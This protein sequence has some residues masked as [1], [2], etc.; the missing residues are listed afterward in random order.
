MKSLLR[1]IASLATIAVVG[2]AAASIEFYDI[3]DD[4]NQPILNAPKLIGGTGSTAITISIPTTLTSLSG[5]TAQLQLFLSD[6]E[7]QPDGEGAVIASLMDKKINIAQNLTP[8]WY[9]WT[10]DAMALMQQSTSPSQLWS[11]SRDLTSQ[12]SSKDFFYYNARLVFT[13]VPEAS[14][15]LLLGVGAMVAA[16]VARQRRQGI[17]RS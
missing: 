15:G 17:R 3:V 9:T 4:N 13:A 14:E 10:G 12:P 1:V 8:S 5:Y 11:F 7:L 16:G 2:P 6:D